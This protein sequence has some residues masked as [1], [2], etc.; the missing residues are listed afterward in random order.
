MGNGAST[1]KAIGSEVGKGTKAVVGSIN[2]P[3][4][5]YSFVL[6][7]II[8]SIVGYIFGWSYY[9]KGKA[10]TLFESDAKCREEV[11]TDCKK[12]YKGYTESVRNQRKQ[13]ISNGLTECPKVKKEV[14]KETSLIIFI[15]T[16]LLISLILSSIIYKIVFYVKNPKAAALITATQYTREA[17]TGKGGGTRK[18]K[19]GMRT[20]R[21]YRGRAKGGRKI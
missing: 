7:F 14:S 4:Y 11:E 3:N 10:I 19:R 12:N 2:A 8:I 16:P 5:L 13:C 21:K 20:K 18:S 17:I 15:V 1:V 9:S 6:P